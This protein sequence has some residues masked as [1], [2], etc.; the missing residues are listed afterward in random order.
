MHV[1]KMAAIFIVVG[2]GYRRM[3]PNYL[4]CIKDTAPTK[5]SVLDV[6]H[7]ALSAVGISSC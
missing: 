4:S 2:V 3:R 1:I 7:I 5:L 6:L